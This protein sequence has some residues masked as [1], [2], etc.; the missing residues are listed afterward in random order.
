MRFFGRI[1]EG[2][3]S[4]FD[5]NSCRHGSAFRVRAT[6]G[7]HSGEADHLPARRDLFI[8]DEDEHEHEMVPVRK[9][10][11]IVVVVIP[12]LIWMCSRIHAHYQEIAK[13]LTMTRFEA[14]PE[15]WNTVLVL[16]TG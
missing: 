10:A 8:D 4:F 2:T 14:L 6:I 5:W 7:V 12:V 15:F 13:H 11:W 16:I 1:M 9:G 3:P